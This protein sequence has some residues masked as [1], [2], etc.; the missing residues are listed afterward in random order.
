MLSP[1]LV[2]LV[3]MFTMPVFGNFGNWLM[4]S[5]VTKWKPLRLGFKVISTCCIIVLVLLVSMELSNE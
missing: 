3:K 1:Q 2:C 4:I 5:L